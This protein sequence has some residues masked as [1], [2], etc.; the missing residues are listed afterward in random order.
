MGKRRN[1]NRYLWAKGFTT[2]KNKERYDKSCNKCHV[3]I[4]MILRGKK[5]KATDVDG[6]PHHC[7]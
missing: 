6:S 2:H 4:T 7:V 5:W 3:A 1:A